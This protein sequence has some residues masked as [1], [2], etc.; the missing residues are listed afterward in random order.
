MILQNSSSELRTPNRERQ[1]YSVRNSDFSVRHSHS[2]IR[3]SLSGKPT[4]LPQIRHSHFSIRHSHSGKPTRL[5]QIRHSH[6]SVR[7][8]SGYLQWHL[9]N[10]GDVKTV[11]EPVL[12]DA[13][14]IE[15]RDAILAYDDQQIVRDESGR[16]QT[17]WD[18]RTTKPH[19]VTGRPVPDESA[20][21]PVYTYQNPRPAPWPQADFIVGNPPFIGASRMRDALGD[22]YVEALRKTIKAVPQSADYVMYWWHRAADLVRSGQ[23][24][25]A[26]G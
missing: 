9:R 16:P 18:G 11:S 10:A 4:R 3:H 26:L 7:N 1:Q 25:M 19:P 20:Q 23:A 15:T 22:G 6:F 13:R 14:N 2:G 24:P 21:L 5:P 12:E 8:S 17:H